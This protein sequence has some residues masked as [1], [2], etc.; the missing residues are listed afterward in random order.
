MSYRYI[1]MFDNLGFECVIDITCDTSHRAEAVI[2][3]EPD[4]QTKIV[5]LVNKMILRAKFNTHRNPEIWIFWSDISE[6]DLFDACEQSPQ[7]MADLIRSR[8]TNLYKM[9]KT[10]TV[11]E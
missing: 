7:Q 11:I 9:P 3:D 10:K 2:N 4:P 1:T 8:G 6:K 5:S